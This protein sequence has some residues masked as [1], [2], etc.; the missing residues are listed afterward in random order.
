[1]TAVF[2]AGILG[3]TVDNLRHAAAGE[4]HETTQMYPDY[5]EIAKK[6][7]FDE[8]AAVFKNIAVAE[9][10]H[11]D[12]YL[13]LA[14]NIESGD[15]FRKNSEVGWV[16]RNCGYIHFGKEAPKVCPACAH[17]QAYYEL[18]KINY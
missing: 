5:A 2:P 10:R 8:V 1:M 11:R 17:P 16:C 12:R 18:E 9:A 15:V 14:K 6:E 4:D 7:G 13:A 3:S